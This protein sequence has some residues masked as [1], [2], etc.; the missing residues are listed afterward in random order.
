L[1]ASVCLSIFFPDHNVTTSNH[2]SS[3]FSCSC[4]SVPS[5]PQSAMTGSAPAKP[6]GFAFST[7]ST[8]RPRLSSLHRAKTPQTPQLE[9]ITEEKTPTDNSSATITTCTDP[10]A[11]AGSSHTNT[12]NS[13]SPKSLQH[14]SFTDR[15]RP[16][17]S[18]TSEVPTASPT[19]AATTAPVSV[20]GGGT[21]GGGTGLEDTATSANVKYTKK[22]ASCRPIWPATLVHGIQVRS[23]AL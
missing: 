20:S 5:W 3:S 9:P 11:P 19:S 12:K 13:T 15:P 23:N 17:N 16:R 8:S 4:P 14:D 1:C 10:T 7:P 2:S 6:D 22:C 21:S 18:N